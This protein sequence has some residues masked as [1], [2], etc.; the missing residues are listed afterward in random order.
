MRVGRHAHAGPVADHVRRH[1]EVGA[2]H[3]IER[4]HEVVLARDHEVEAVVVVGD[5]QV[6]PHVRDDLIGEDRHRRAEALGQVEG[7]DRQP[8]RFLHRRRREHDRLEVAAVARVARDVE[9]ALARRSRDA[10]D[11][12]H[13]HGIDDHQWD[14]VGDGPAVSVV[15]QRVA[16]PRRRRHRLEATEARTRAGVHAGQLVL[17]LHVIPADLGQALGHVLGDVGR[18]R[19]RI[20]GEDAAARGDGALGHRVRTGLQQAAALDLAPGPLLPRRDQ[21][22]LHGVL[23]GRH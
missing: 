12:P 19:D 20:A 4:H 6:F 7:V 8:E 16:G 22:L 11:R 1:V 18:R 9:L 3:R 10:A 23:D 15:H 21:G 14:L 5:E 13:P 17:A 2:A